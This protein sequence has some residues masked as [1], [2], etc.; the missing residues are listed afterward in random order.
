M[1]TKRPTADDLAEDWWEQ[2]EDQSSSVTEPAVK[3]RK[4]TT[5][6]QRSK[7][8]D[9][10]HSEQKKKKR[11]KKP[12]EKKLQR[13]KLQSFED[14]HSAI[15]QY[16]VLSSALQK[17]YKKK[18]TE[19]EIDQIELYESWFVDCRRFSPDEEN[20]EKYFP[21]FF[22]SV[23]S[24]WDKHLSKLNSVGSPLVLLVGSAALRL[25]SLNRAAKPVL[26]KCVVAKLFAK[27]IKISEQ[28]TFLQ[29]KVV[30]FAIGTPNRVAKLISSGDLNLSRLRLVILDWYWRDQKQRKMEDI[31]EVRL[32]RCAVCISCT[33]CQI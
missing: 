24:K 11:K 16:Q 8:E 20:S 5:S 18:L 9:L 19:F 10:V 32:C 23:Y 21:A 22:K 2:P 28:E 14:Q 7:G 27:H 4:D 1:A 3:K 26:G 29:S 6:E 13:E 15:Y 25:Q 31:P 33:C 30:G 12:V 17:Y